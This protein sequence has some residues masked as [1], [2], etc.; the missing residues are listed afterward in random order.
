[1]KEKFKYKKTNSGMF[2]FGLKIPS[3]YPGLESIN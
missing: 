1:M 2:Y 3:K